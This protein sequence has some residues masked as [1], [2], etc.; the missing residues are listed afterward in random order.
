MCS[1]CVTV[2]PWYCV[3]EIQSI[4][5]MCYCRTSKALR[6]VVE[7]A[8][9]HKHACC[10]TARLHDLFHSSVHCRP[11]CILATA[12]LRFVC[13]LDGSALDCSINCTL[14]PA[15]PLKRRLSPFQIHLYTAMIDC[16]PPFQLELVFK[17]PASNLGKLAASE[18]SGDV[19][20]CWSGHCMHNMPDRQ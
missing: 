16:L 11:Y 5:G 12:T 4:K 2:H 20:L 14:C 13:V 1:Q 18:L 7:L 9:N 6:N 17:K 19:Q 15:T 10:I 3:S 8:R